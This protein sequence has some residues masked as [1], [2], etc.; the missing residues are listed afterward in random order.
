MNLRPSAPKADAL[1]SCATS[2][3]NSTI[4]GEN[5][6]TTSQHHELLHYLT[7]NHSIFVTRV[8]S[9]SLSRHRKLSVGMSYS[10]YY[11]SLPSWRRGFD[12]RHPLSLF[13]AYKKRCVFPQEQRFYYVLAL[14]AAYYPQFN[15]SFAT[16][17][18]GTVRAVQEWIPL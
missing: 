7:C 9:G 14:S 17:I 1:P 13:T 15:D 16:A 2:R 8:F 3:S 10:G 11:P 6:S 5:I 18:S 12:S 4:H